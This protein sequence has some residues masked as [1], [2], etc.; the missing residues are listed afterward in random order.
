MI[1]ARLTKED[2]GCSCC[3]TWCKMTVAKLNCIFLFLPFYLNNLP[4]EVEKRD[5]YKIKEAFK[6][7]IITD[8]FD[9]Q[10]INAMHLFN[11]F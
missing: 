1:Q 2:I 5:E 8:P 9:F 10:I 11:W 3:H 6:H 7:L 4:G